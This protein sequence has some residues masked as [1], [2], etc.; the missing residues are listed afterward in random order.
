MTFFQDLRYGMRMLMKQP[1]FT[2]VAVLALT[3]GIGANTAIFSVVNAVLLRPLPY[4]ESDRLVMVNERSEQMD[5]MSIS[6]PNFTDW[7]AQNRVF[8]NFA[9]FNRGSYNLTGIGEPERL[10]A[11]QVSADLFSVLRVNAW[12]GRVFTN[13]EDQ[14][15]A[16]SVVMLSHGLWKR[17]FGSDEKIL[18]QDITLNN[19]SYTVIGIMPEGFLF[20]SRVDM[21]VP[22]G[23]LSAQESWKQRGNHPGLYGVGRLNPGVTIEQARADMDSIAENLEKQYPDSN[24]GNRVRIVPLLENYVQDIRPALWI[25]LSAVGMVLLI[26]CANVAN[27][28]LARATTRQKEMAVRVALGAS[29]WRIIRQMLTESVV[30]ALVGGGL[31]L[32]LANWGVALILA[33]SPNGI[34]R[35]REVDLDLRVLGFTLLIAVLTGLLFGIIPALQASRLDVHGTLKETGRGNTGR[36]HWLRSGLVIGEMAMTLILLVGAGLLIRSFYQLQQ[37]NPG[38]S[39]DNL[40]SFSV[41]LPQ[42]KY[43]T[44]QQRINFFQQVIQNLQSTAGVEHVGLAS[45]LPLGNNG[46]QTSFT[47]DGQ[48]PPA[49]GQTPLLEACL[50]SPDYFK[51]M[52]IPLIRG[53]YFTEQDNRAHLTEEKLRGL[54]PDMASYMGL[55]AIIIDEEFARRYFPDEDPIGKHIRMGGTDPKNPVATVVGVVGRVKMD[56]L[57]TDSN[58]VQ[59]YFPFLQT[60]QSGMTVVVKSSGDPVKMVAAARQ[61][62]LAV[63][64]DQPIY[65]IRTMD[66]IKSES[67]STERLNLTLLGIFAG[68]A[69]ILALIGIYGVM[70]YAVS[71]RT[72]EIGIRM[73]LGA[74]ISDVMKMVIGEGMKMAVIGLS[75]G[76]AGAFAVTRFMEGMLFGVKP[77]DLT[78]FA[79]VSVILAGVA[80]VACFVPARRATKVDPMIALRYE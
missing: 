16:Q 41:S 4:E 75:I 33:I 12:R 43:Q 66:E 23:P 3:L 7:K 21:W 29:R 59:G 22:V 28:L 31:G 62:I 38:F 34:P 44:D 9:V 69:L 80:L 5:G 37:V 50:V 63:D 15:G 60:P 61:Q 30:L 26:A 46:W 14:P 36:H 79:A 72:N 55:N 24:Q 2:L 54:S 20:P 71:Q 11:G 40:L 73:A 57:N 18:N 39:Y 42:K 19:R 17:R 58:R 70:S 77:T 48:P 10:Q 65:E 64:H 76:L 53:R 27:L 56:G 67:I 74:Q 32:L 8:E 52:N 51:A 78:T 1:L 13:D 35:S 6:Y 45:G 25:L 49:P 47:I 68:V